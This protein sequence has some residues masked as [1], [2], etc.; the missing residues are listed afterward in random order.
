MGKFSCV[1]RCLGTRLISLRSSRFVVCLK[2]RPGDIH[3]LPYDGSTA[4]KGVLSFSA[5]T[6]LANHRFQ[7]GQGHSRCWRRIVLF[8]YGGRLS[9]D[10]IS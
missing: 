2:R 6:F 1:Q 9:V 5:Q 4:G 10:L 8:S 3:G 7:V